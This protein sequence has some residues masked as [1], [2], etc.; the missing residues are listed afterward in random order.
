[1]EGDIMAV[2]PALKNADVGIKNKNHWPGNVM[3]FQFAHGYR[4]TFKF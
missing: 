2:A 4:K 3:P 1:M